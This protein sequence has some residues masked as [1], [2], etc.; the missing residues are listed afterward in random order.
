MKPTSTLMLRRLLNIVWYGWIALWALQPTSLNA[1]DLPPPIGTWWDGVRTVAACPAK[2]LTSDQIKWLMRH[3]FYLVNYRGQQAYVRFN[4]IQ[5]GARPILGNISMNGI[6]ISVCA[7]GF[8]IQGAANA[9]AAHHEF[10]HQIDL[11]LNGPVPQTPGA[12]QKQDALRLG[13]TGNVQQPAV[14][15]NPPERKGDC[16][17]TRGP[18]KYLIKTCFK[19]G[20]NYGIYQII[21][22]NSD[23]SESFR[24]VE[25]LLPP[26]PRPSPVPGLHPPSQP[27]GSPASGP[28]PWGK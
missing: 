12:P 20:Q 23:G 8:L 17:Q 7:A 16:E 26:L 22:V 27:G 25:E 14:R 11:T 15:T 13:M 4:P 5:P 6:L 19:K 24:T 3:D 2:G 10:M 9:Q 28:I 21:S 18:G 1:A